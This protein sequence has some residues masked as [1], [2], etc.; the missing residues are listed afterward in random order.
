MKERG[1]R[2]SQRSD[3]GNQHS[4][5][6]QLSTLADLGIPRDRASRAMQ[7]ADVPEEEFEAARCQ[8]A[9]PAEEHPQ[10]VLSS[11]AARA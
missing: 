5:A 2:A 10:A 8:I 9:R 1:E 11:R 7:L 4:S 6:A 3:R